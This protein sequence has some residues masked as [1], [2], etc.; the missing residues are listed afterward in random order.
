MEIPG[1]LADISTFSGVGIQGGA[2]LG[3]GKTRRSLKE[4]Q[5]GLAGTFTLSGSEVKD[6]I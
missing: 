3:P 2:Q 4:I 5:E 6:R 1:K